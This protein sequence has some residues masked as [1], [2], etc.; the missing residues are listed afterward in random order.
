[1]LR[2]IQRLKNPASLSP[3]LRDNQLQS[4]IEDYSIETGLDYEQ[5]K[6]VLVAGEWGGT[7]TEFEGRMKAV[8]EDPAFQDDEIL[9]EGRSLF[10]QFSVWLLSRSLWVVLF[11][12]FVGFIVNASWLSAIPVIKHI[13]LNN[14]KQISDMCINYLY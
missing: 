2:R 9:A 4:A 13:R 14:L 7:P 10:H 12:C 8:L 11:S 5:S 6:S 1:M 3:S